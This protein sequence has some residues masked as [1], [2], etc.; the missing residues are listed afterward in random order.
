MLLVTAATPIELKPL[1]GNAPDLAVG[2]VASFEL[3]NGIAID[4][5]LT[6]VGA[7]PAAAN[8]AMAIM[9][10]QYNIVLSIG[11]AGAFSETLKIGDVVLVATDCFADYGI[12]NNGQFVWLYRSG[13]VSDNELPFSAGKL[14]SHGL[15]TIVGIEHLNKVKGITVSMASGSDI[16]IEKWN[17]LFAPD[18]E[19]MEVAALMYVCQ[20]AK[21]PLA[22]LRGISNRV[23]TRNVANWDIP[24]STANV[25]REA[26]NIIR[27]N[28]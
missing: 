9:K 18:I 19:T 24:N 13:L 2:Q 4:V 15:E 14:L 26:M 11:I 22:C 25:C 10:S 1:V 21:V 5:L 6:G 23:E 28:S 12:D 20:M 3:E 16:V 8:L 27:S 7:A 17:P